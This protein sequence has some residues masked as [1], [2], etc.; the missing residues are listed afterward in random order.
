MIEGSKGCRVSHIQDASIH[1]KQ[2]PQ[3]SLMHFLIE[4]LCL[5][6]QS[7]LALDI[8]QLSGPDSHQNTLKHSELK[9]DT[10]HII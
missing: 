1:P 3:T 9:L 2:S 4:E 6:Q 10:I 5:Q 7:V 8:F